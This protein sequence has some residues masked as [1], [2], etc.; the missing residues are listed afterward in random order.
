MSSYRDPAPRGDV[1]PSEEEIDPAG[2]GV[3]P[4]TGPAGTVDGSA[5]TW[6]AAGPWASRSRRP[7]PDHRP[8]S[9]PAPGRS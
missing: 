8:G 3:E 9:T 5:V 2:N 4:A 7:P 6:S 1:Y